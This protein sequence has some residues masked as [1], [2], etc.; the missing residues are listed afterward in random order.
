MS[1]G[2]GNTQKKV[3]LLLSSGLALCF[4]RLLGDHCKIVESAA[5]EWRKINQRSLKQAIK[6]LYRSKLVEWKENQ[7]DS[8]TLVLT[9]KGKNKFVTFN[10]DNLKIDKPK[11]WDKRWRIITFDIPEKYRSARDALRGHLK[12]MGFFEFQKSVFVYPYPYGDVIDFLVEF[13]NIKKGVRQILAEDL[14][15]S[16]DLK[17]HFDL[18]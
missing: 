3:L 15:N 13:Y 5:D 11:K 9:E 16:L 1:R 7:D 4:S 10:P 12:Q 2:L 18:L 8:V 14:D 6:N 17:N